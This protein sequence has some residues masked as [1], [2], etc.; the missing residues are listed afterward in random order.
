M[1]K[2]NEIIQRI[3]KF[4]PLELAESW[5]NSGWQINLHN[6]CVEKIMLCTS[7]TK[8]V[9]RQA[10]EKN[11][12]LIIAHHPL[13]FPSVNNI[14][15]DII[16]NAVKNDISIYSAHTNIDKAKFGMNYEFAKNI[17]LNI[18]EEQDFVRIGEFEGIKT[19]DNII[20]ELKVRFNLEKIKVVNYQTLKPVKRVAVCTG[21][22]AEF[23]N[24]LKNKNIDLYITSDLKYHNVVDVNN[25]AIIDMG[26]LESEKHF[27]NIIKNVIIDLEM[28]IETA[29]EKPIWTF[30]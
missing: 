19:L 1:A 29:N 2:I 9:L 6:D 24:D 3:E 16:I 28:E 27:T 12:K 11:C 20:L 4:A 23:I 14:S 17:G 30:V 5:D 26:H 13:I 22:G 25:F 18:V 8:D 21:A 15:E 10:I 7:C